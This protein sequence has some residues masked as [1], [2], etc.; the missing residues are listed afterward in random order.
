MSVIDPLKISLE[1]EKKTNKQKQKQ[2]KKQKQKQNKQNKTKQNKTKQKQ[3]Q[4]QTNLKIPVQP[5]ETDIIKCSLTIP[6]KIALWLLTR[7]YWYAVSGTTTVH[8]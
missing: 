4:K 8:K 7:V 6:S 2:N 3:K 5:F 1:E